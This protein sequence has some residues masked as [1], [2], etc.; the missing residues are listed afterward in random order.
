[1]ANDSCLYAVHLY[2]SRSCVDSL[3]VYDSEL[4]FDCTDCW[5]CYAL[6]YSQNCTNCSES[7]FL[8]NCIGC[9]FCI[10]CV[11]ARNKEYWIFNEQKTKEE[12][13]A[14]VKELQ[15]G[16]W[17]IIQS[18]KQKFKE[19]AVKFPNKCLQGE[20]NE[21]SAGDYLKNTQ[22]CKE[23]FD[24]CDSQD[25][26]YTVESRNFKKVYDVTI[27]GAN[28]G[29]EYCYED[30]EIGDAVRNICFSD[31]VWTGS[32]DLLYC[33]LCPNGC[34]NLFGCCGMQH[35]EYCILNK[36]YSKEEY[37]ELVPKIIEHMKSTGE[38]GEF[39][40]SAMSP[41]AYNETVAQEHYPLTK[42]EAL[43]Q[44]Y[45][46]KDDIDEPLQVEKIIRAD[47]LPDKLDDTPDDILN[48]AI[49]CQA[50]GRPF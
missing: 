48:W 22:R 26:K 19:F 2:N 35:A 15:G 3:Y 30:H 6:R 5:N 42:A 17:S 18:W 16:S 41:F 34:A 28:K 7:W 20:Q 4:C 9:K 43:E 12:Y 14:L 21:D 10:G 40:P 49:E 36:Q 39:F 8:K 44:G 32:H 13:E 31:Q 11:N 47:Q 29:V 50:S 25:C 45:K 46:W 37:E 33:K 38:W 23:C 27:F 24:V 1:M